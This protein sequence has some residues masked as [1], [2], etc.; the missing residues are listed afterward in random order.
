MSDQNESNYQAAITEIAAEIKEPLDIVRAATAAMHLA[1]AAPD[2]DAAELAD[3]NAELWV[4]WALERIEG[5]AVNE[6]AAI[7]DQILTLSV[8]ISLYDV[9]D[10][11]EDEGRRV[12]SILDTLTPKRFEECRDAAVEWFEANLAHVIEA[13]FADITEEL[14]Q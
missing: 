11:D 2:E 3:A 13:K 10:D 7:Q 6:R 4:N 8:M 12:E 5:L 14:E 9:D 1:Y